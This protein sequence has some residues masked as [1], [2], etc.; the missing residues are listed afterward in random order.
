MIFSQKKLSKD[1][2]NIDF[3]TIPIHE[4]LN[5]FLKFDEQVL[6]NLNFSLNLSLSGENFKIIKKIFSSLPPSIYEL[7]VIDSFCN[8]SIFLSQK[9][10]KRIEISDN[11]VHLKKALE[12]YN[13]LNTSAKSDKYYRTIGGINNL[14]FNNLLKQNVENI[15]LYPNE[16]KSL[17]CKSYSGNQKNY[18]YITSFISNSSNITEAAKKSVNFNST[19]GN[20][21]LALL[22]NGI[23]CI[24]GS[25]AANEISKQLDIS[26]YVDKINN[27]NNQKIFNAVT[28]GISNDLINRYDEITSGD[29]ILLLKSQET[30]SNIANEFYRLIEDGLLKHFSVRAFPIDEGII[31]GL[32][33]IDKGFEI[34]LDKFPLT[35]YSAEELLIN[36]NLEYYLL[37]VNKKFLRQITDFCKKR[38]FDC[39]EIGIISKNKT[40]KLKK[41]SLVFSNIK[42]D[43]FHLFENQS[44]TYRI[45][46]Q[47]RKIENK[48]ELPIDLLI[49]NTIESL[50]NSFLTYNYQPFRLGNVLMPPFNGIKQL[51]KTSIK[52]LTP[53]YGQDD[54]VLG[55][56]HNDLLDEYPDIFTN[57]VNSI[58]SAVLKL[59]AVGYPFHQCASV[60][61]ILLNKSNTAIKQGLLLS[62]LLG[63]LYVQLIFS[64]PTIELKI[65]SLDLNLEL[66]IIS[67]EAMSFSNN[68]IIT[69]KFKV[70][71]KLFL[72]PIKK[73]PLGIPDIKYLL[74]LTTAFNI[75][76]LSKNIQSAKFISNNIFTSVIELTIGDSLGFSF[77]LT[78]KT[79]LFSKTT[80]ILAAVTDIKEIDNIDSTYIGVI[81]DTGVIRLGNNNINLLDISK[82]L[83]DEENQINTKIINLETDKTN[84]DKLFNRHIDSPEVLII[85]FDKFSSRVFRTVSH[86]SGFRYNERLLYKYTKITDDFIKGLRT[87]ILKAQVVIFSGENSSF[88]NLDGDTM[89]NIL[90]KPAI[91]D[92]INE[93]LFRNK[94]LIFCSGEGMRAVIK[95]GF[96]PYG[97]AE[98][99]SIE[100]NDNLIDQP[101][102]YLN[103][104]RISNN[105]GP[106][107]REIKAGEI[108]EVSSP[109]DSMQ[110][111]KSKETDKIFASGVIVAQY[112][113]ADGD[114]SYNKK[115]NPTGSNLSIASLCSAEGQVIGFVSPIE[116]T[117]FLMSDNNIIDNLF[118]SAKKY[119]NG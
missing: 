68:I 87:D 114:M 60:I 8:S 90:R 59:V 75:Q 62:S 3:S 5:G 23:N 77:A 20:E 24:D 35:N 63:I 110:I 70:G 94:G 40:I 58:L 21:K 56:A 101:K 103:R 15:F 73:D 85:T 31:N 78:D 22:I 54:L 55:I 100:L 46:N 93:L 105:K 48:N 26:L 27:V 51:I 118:S 119:F 28:I 92:A 39:F 97:N 111:T 18:S 71:Q 83:P 50:E 57:T 14:A 61:S 34:Y 16:I 115:Y 102:A 99:K 29:I 108:Y 47:G 113:D 43:Y 116:K 88:N 91:L 6:Y 80:S 96:I 19:L 117:Y 107:L 30:N 38:S 69:D 11:N 25:L 49:N 76:I 17:K 104:I 74:K 33:T 45:G 52:T 7:S 95:L 72:F 9:K 98:N 32:I 79:L 41:D 82:K 36:G 44:T 2:V 37:I 1:S 65:N 12:L 112:I 86:K 109:V 84:N 53:H 10:I 89:Y 81:D 13:E 4:R 67:I 64:I 106:W 66:P 42:L